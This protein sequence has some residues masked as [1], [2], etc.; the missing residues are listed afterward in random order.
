MGKLIVAVY[1]VLR[2]PGFLPPALATIVPR[3]LL[4]ISIGTP[5]FMVIVSVFRI[6]PAGTWA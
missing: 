4:A 6:I 5:A 2:R 1:N 3:L